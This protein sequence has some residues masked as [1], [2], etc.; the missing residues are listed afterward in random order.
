[1][2]LCDNF[3]EVYRAVDTDRGIE[4]AWNKIS[5]DRFQLDKQQIL[6]EME[7]FHGIKHQNII[8]FNHFWIDEDKKQVVYITEL[9][10]SGT[11]L[12]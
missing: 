5:L 11:L 1:M 12:K 7:S 6:Q 8:E 4:V 2:L 10:P 3:K 9:L